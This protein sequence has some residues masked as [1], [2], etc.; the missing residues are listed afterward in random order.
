MVVWNSLKLMETMGEK[1]RMIRNAL[2]EEAEEV[3]E[4]E[5]GRSR[6]RLEHA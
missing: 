2:E 1:A 4:V 6:N 3:E 5:E